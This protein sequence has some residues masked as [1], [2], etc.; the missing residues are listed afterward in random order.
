M[1]IDVTDIVSTL[2]TVGGSL[3]VA[4]GT[5][6]VTIKKDRDKSKND[7]M[8]TLNEHYAKNQA[9]INELKIALKE[10]INSI[11]DDITQV[12]ATVQNQISIID[13]NLINLT[14]QV[15]KHNQVVERTYKLEQALSDLGKRIV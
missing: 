8:S 15:E 4:F 9:D 11:Q 12:N 6:H 5:W 10:D 13:T 3:V 2:I 1:T 14:K 7:L